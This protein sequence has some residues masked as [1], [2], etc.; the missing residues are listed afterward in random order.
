MSI[1]WINHSIS[2]ELNNCQHFIQCSKLPSHAL[3]SNLSLSEYD[4]SYIYSCVIDP[5]LQFYAFNIDATQLP[6][7]ERHLLD[8]IIDDFHN[9]FPNE[10]PPH[11]PPKRDGDHRIDLIPSVA[12]VSISPYRLSRLEEKEIAKQLKEYLSMGRIKVSKSPWGAPVL[13]VKKKEGSWRMCINYRH[14]NKMTIR[15]VYPLPR[16]NDLID[17][18]HGAQYFTKIDLRTGYH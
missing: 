17:C 4:S 12:P 16:A 14:L 7:H 15:N 13:L 11:L 10:W 2:F 3:V 1:D 5:V 18:L 6:R 8:S 9:V